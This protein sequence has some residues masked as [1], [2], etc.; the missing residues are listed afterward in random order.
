MLLKQNK[1]QEALLI[2]ES[3]K[4]RALARLLGEETN[5]SDTITLD[6]VKMLVQT[7]NTR[8]LIY[9]QVNKE[10]FASWLVTED[11]T[12]YFRKIHIRLSCSLDDFM[13]SLT[14]SM[15]V[16]G[17][18]MQQSSELCGRN[19]ETLDKL[20]D[21]VSF[22]DVE[23][24]TTKQADDAEDK[25]DELLAELYKALIYPVEDLVNSH[26]KLMIIP[27]EQLFN[28]PW[29]ALMDSQG[30]YLIQKVS[31]QVVPSLLVWKQISKLLSTCKNPENQRALFVGNPWPVSIAVRKLEHAQ[32]EAESG[33]SDRS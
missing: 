23:V 21:K 24:S 32:V 29:A 18:A 25:E 8:A 27:A 19:P 33:L 3:S 11:G 14:D 28:I 5:L 6:D 1:A 7:E 17:H 20:T 12:I 31:I 26:D 13:Q 22:A 2:A 10:D 4:A 15:G 16:R 30:Y 9:S